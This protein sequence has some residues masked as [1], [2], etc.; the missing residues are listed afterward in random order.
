MRSTLPSP[1]TYSD[2]SN[3]QY[4]PPPNDLVKSECTSSCM[5]KEQ[6][7]YISNITTESVNKLLCL[8]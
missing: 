2:T 8:Q 3:Q 4:L 1:E 5:K 7:E 6:T